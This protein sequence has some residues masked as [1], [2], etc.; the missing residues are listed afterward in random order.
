MQRARLSRVS[1]C[2]CVPKQHT[3]DPSFRFSSVFITFVTFL[4]LS[5]NP[6]PD[7]THRSPQL[8]LWATFL[9]VSSVALTGFQY[10]PQVAHTY[11]LKLVGA[12]SIPMMILQAPGAVLM[13]VSIALRWVYRALR[14]PYSSLTHPIPHSGQGRTGQVSSALPAA[15]CA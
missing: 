2:C 15:V 3:S 1:Y 7:A 9:G 11:R 14:V 12:L 6:T 13:V 5:T 4:L 10:A 8:E